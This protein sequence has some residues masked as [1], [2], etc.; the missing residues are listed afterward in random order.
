M[1]VYY[2]NSAG[3]DLDTLF[4]TDNGNAGALGFL[5]PNGQ[6]LGNRYVNTSLGYNV[7]YLNSAGTD[8]GYLRGYMSDPS[9]ATNSLTLTRVQSNVSG[10]KFTVGL[11]WNFSS[12]TPIDTLKVT[13]YWYLSYVR[14]DGG[15]TCYFTDGSYTTN[16][17]S[18]GSFGEHTSR[19]M[20][21][22]TYTINSNTYERMYTTGFSG[23][24][25]HTTWETWVN[26]VAT[27]AVGSVSLNSNHII[28]YMD[29]E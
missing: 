23:G 29:R 8:L 24:W 18:Q 19:S 28:F 2:Y 20:G 14:F 4:Y 7:G 5:A 9:G 27:N 6:D 21:T 3:S 25:Y 15:G 10:T 22:F 11:R 26:V 12:S 16:P 13:Y 17:A 1:A